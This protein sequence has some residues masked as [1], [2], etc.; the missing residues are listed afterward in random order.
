MGLADLEALAF[1]APPK[2]TPTA[3]LKAVLELFGYR[4][5]DVPAGGANAEFV[6]VI[7]GATA[8]WALT[9]PGPAR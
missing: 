5:S 2:T 6:K 7:A 3:L 4:E 8:G 9:G 1:V